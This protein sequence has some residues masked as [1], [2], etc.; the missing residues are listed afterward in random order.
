MMYTPL[1][2]SENAIAVSSTS[3]RNCGWRQAFANRMPVR[4][5]ELLTHWRGRIKRQRLV[6]CFI[7]SG[8]K[9]SSAVR[10]LKLFLGA[11]ASRPQMSA[12]RENDLACFAR[13]A[14]GP[15]ALP[16]KSL[17]NFTRPLDSN[18]RARSEPKQ[19]SGS[20][21]RLTCQPF[22]KSWIHLREM[23]PVSCEHPWPDKLDRHVSGRS[24]PGRREMETRSGIANRQ[25]ER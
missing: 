22:C 25:I 14:G 18:R 19:F 23:F 1:A 2:V 6:N 8:A 20:T 5:K 21:P 17:N 9:V 4:T 11:R 7:R 3:R 10:K 15:P 13:S 16:G 24:H 12:K